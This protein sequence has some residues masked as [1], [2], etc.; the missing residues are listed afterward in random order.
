MELSRA[1][2]PGEG[3]PGAGP[4]G[5]ATDTDWLLGGGGAGKI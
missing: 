1:V 4:G 2:R 3:L 5:G